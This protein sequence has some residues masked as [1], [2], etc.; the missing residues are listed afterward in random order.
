MAFA[1]HERR[2]SMIIE[3]QSTRS[4]PASFSVFLKKKMLSALGEN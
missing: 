1:V 3:L 4:T 2:Q